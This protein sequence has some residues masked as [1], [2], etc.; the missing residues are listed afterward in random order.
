MKKIR[1]GLVNGGGGVADTFLFTPCFAAC[2][3]TLEV[4][5]DTFW[6]SDLASVLSSICKIEFV[7]NP[8]TQEESFLRYG[9]PHDGYMGWNGLHAARNYLRL[10]GL[11][12]NPCIPVAK[13]PSHELAWAHGFLSQ[14]RN[15]VVFTPMPGGYQNKNDHAARGKFLPPEYWKPILQK[16]SEHRD[17][18][19]FTSA[20]NYV[21]MPHT[22]PLKGFPVSKIAAAMEYTKRHLGIE[23]GLLHM[24]VALGCKSHVYIPSLGFYKNHCFPA[25]IYTKEM[26]ELSGQSPRVYYHLFSETGFQ[27]DKE[28]ENRPN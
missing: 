22:V 16:L 3:T 10:F 17:I 15:P 25:Y 4:A 2:D 13:S 6:A 5:C 26:F 28:H 1:F 27:I 11:P 23:N 21:E 9:K 19:Y 12:P 24:A 18:L 7:K 14:Y 20:Q 8:I